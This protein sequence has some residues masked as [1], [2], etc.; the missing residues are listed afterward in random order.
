MYVCV[1]I[2]T[3]NAYSN[4]S[5]VM[6]IL[7]IVQVFHLVST[8]TIDFH[9]QTELVCNKHQVCKRGKTHF[10]RAKSVESE[11]HDIV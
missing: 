7:S 10:G 5:I 2:D 3:L 4:L 6:K 1:F 8:S 9:K 11:L